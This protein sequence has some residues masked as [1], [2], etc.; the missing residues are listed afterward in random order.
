VAVLSWVVV[1]NST[2]FMVKVTPG[3]DPL[4]K[5]AIP[6][7]EEEWPTPIVE[8]EWADEDALPF[9]LCISARLPAPACSFI[10]ASRAARWFPGT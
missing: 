2:T 4:F 1:L 9:P 7:S 8:I 3:E 6:G 10:I 5:Q